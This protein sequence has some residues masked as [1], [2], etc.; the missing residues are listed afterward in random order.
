MSRIGRTTKKGYRLILLVTMLVVIA[1]GLLRGVYPLA[2]TGDTRVANGYYLY[3][4]PPDEEGRDSTGKPK[5]VSFSEGR[6]TDGNLK[7]TG[8]AV[9]WKRSPVGTMSVVFDLLGDRALENISIAIG[10]NPNGWHAMA[11]MAVSYRAERD[12]KLRVADMKL[13]WPGGSVVPYRVDGDGDAIL[14]GAEM[15]LIRRGG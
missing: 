1:L 8:K 15:K 6:L 11:T 12:A 7:K 3:Q 10:P 9:C 5:A 4:L 13:M 14:R 2:A